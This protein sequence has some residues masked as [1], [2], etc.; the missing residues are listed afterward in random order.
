M[1]DESVEFGKEESQCHWIKLL[2]SNKHF[3][4]SFSDFVEIVC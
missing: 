2:I 4:N 1:S 3:E